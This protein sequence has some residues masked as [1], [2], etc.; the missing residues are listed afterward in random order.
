MRLAELG[1]LGVHGVFFLASQG[2]SAAP[3]PLGGFGGSAFAEDGVTPTL[4]TDAMKKALQLMYDLKF[5]HKVTP[6]EAAYNVADGLFKDG[7]AAFI[8]NGDWTLGAYA[9]APDAEA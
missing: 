7:K 5:T 2:G 8:I 3:I 6:T 4:D 1:Q 9:A